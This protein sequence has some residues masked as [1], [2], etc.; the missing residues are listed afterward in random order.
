[1]TVQESALRLAREIIRADGVHQSGSLNPAKLKALEL[2]HVLDR[3]VCVEHLA[4]HL[5][6]TTNYT[7]RLVD[8]MKEAGILLTEIEETQQRPR[9]VRS[10]YFCVCSNHQEGSR[11]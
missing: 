2:I 11:S 4:H 1:V 6:W 10:L 9:R 3:P 7:Y 8:E 5:G